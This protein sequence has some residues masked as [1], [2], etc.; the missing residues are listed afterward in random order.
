V[1][2]NVYNIKAIMPIPKES[3]NTNFNI[4]RL[5]LDNHSTR[6]AQQLKGQ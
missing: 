3:I 6:V 1:A 4:T 2:V 5:L